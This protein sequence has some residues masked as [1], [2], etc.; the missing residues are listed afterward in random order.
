MLILCYLNSTC[1]NSIKFCI[2]LNDNF[3]FPCMIP[4]PINICISLYININILLICLTY[5]YI[6]PSCCINLYFWYI[7][8]HICYLIHLIYCTIVNA[9][10]TTVSV[11]FLNI[12]YIAH[13]LLQLTIAM[14]QC[15]YVPCYYIII[16]F[17]NR[18]IVPITAPATPSLPLPPLPRY[19]SRHSLVTTPATPATPSLPL[20][21]YHSPFTVLHGCG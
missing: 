19:H 9:Y 17:I 1:C 5:F 16:T 20:P 21:R 7:Y 3:I 11:W 10:S 14:L 13:L 15:F 8:L 6:L 2:I 18:T 12:S 4:K